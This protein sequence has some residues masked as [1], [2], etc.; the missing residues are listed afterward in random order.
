MYKLL[1]KIDC[2]ACAYELRLVI[3]DPNFLTNPSDA[4]DELKTVGADFE[5]AEKFCDEE[6]PDDDSY[7]IIGTLRTVDLFK[8]L[9]DLEDCDWVL[10]T[11]GCGCDCC[12]GEKNENR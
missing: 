6:D 3:D 4:L 11:E 12:G 5:F 10:P 2:E 9:M 8:T 7:L 1:D